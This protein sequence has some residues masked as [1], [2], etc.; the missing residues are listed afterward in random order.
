MTSYGRQRQPGPVLPAE[1]SVA[2]YD[3]QEFTSSGTWTKPAG[4]FT[5]ALIFAHGGGG[6]GGAA[7]NLNGL[8]E[9]GGGGGAAGG[10]AIVMVPLDQMGATET[11]TIGAGGTGGPGVTW[12]N[13]NSHGTSGGDTTVTVTGGDDVVGPGGHYGY[14]GT[15]NG[16]TSTAPAAS[17]YTGEGARGSDN[18][19]LGGNGGGGQENG[20]S[21]GDGTGGDGG[22]GTGCAGGAGGVFAEPGGNGED[23]PE[24]LWGAIGGGGGGGTGGRAGN[25]KHPG[26]NGGYPSGGGGGS[27][28]YADAAGYSEPGGDGADGKATVVCV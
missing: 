11:V 6:G 3:V 19:R 26:G 28:F 1:A 13:E 15:D 2:T 22:A 16:G 5:M 17:I 27:G 14:G 18:D 10:L 25:E 9:C 23:A 4:D 20:E 12:G 24:G 21:T 7:S 8:D